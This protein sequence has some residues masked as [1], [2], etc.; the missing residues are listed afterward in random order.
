MPNTTKKGPS[1]LAG[2]MTHLAAMGL[3]DIQAQVGGDENTG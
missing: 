3:F 2:A 1:P